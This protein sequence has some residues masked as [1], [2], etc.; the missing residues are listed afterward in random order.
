MDEPGAPAPASHATNLA[1]ALTTSDMDATTQV[2]IDHEI[3]ATSDTAAAG[4]LQSG[5]IQAPPPDADASD[6]DTAHAVADAI[7]VPPPY[8]HR[9]DQAAYDP[10]T[11][12]RWHLHDSR[13]WL[14]ED[15][16]EPLDRTPATAHH[17][18]IAI[19]DAINALHW[20][21]PNVR[22]ALALGHGWRMCATCVPSNAP[23]LGPWRCPRVG[24]TTFALGAP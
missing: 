3:S 6:G 21:Q 19:R 12:P 11:R 20:R 16:G 18:D 2:M 24:A 4:H 5:D 8:L 9:Y 23:W 14:A 17:T 10:R 13:L 22:G 15:D 1:G 7:A